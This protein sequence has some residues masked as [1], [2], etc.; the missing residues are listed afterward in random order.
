MP[1]NRRADVPGAGGTGGA[2][3][4]REQDLITNIGEKLPGTTAQKGEVV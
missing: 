2:W 1:R 3:Q 4:H